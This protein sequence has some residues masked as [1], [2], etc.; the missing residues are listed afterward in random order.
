MAETTR[1]VSTRSVIWQAVLDLAAMQ[2]AFS[3]RDIQRVT[4]LKYAVVDDHLDRLYED[5][6]LHRVCAGTYVVTQQFPPDDPI[7]VTV[8]VDGR[9]KVEVGD[10][11]LSLN[12]SGGRKLGSLLQGMAIE[13]SQLQSHGDLSTSVA[14][15][16]INER[17]RRTLDR[18]LQKRVEEISALAQPAEPMRKNLAKLKAVATA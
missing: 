16:E 14:R 1:N 8:L 9:L 18:Y 6:K 2:P 17:K 12:P 13:L 15:L 5:Q 4:G 7:S 11:V 3:R 10:V